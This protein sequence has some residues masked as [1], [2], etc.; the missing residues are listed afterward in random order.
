VIAACATA[1]WSLAAFGTGRPVDATAPMEQLAARIEHADSIHPDIVHD[2][3]RIL[4]VLQH[5]CSRTVCDP[6][7]QARNRA[8]RLRL[9][10]LIAAKTRS[11]VLAVSGGG[12]NAAGSV[13][14]IERR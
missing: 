10:A 6:G 1:A 7:L 3:T 8:V 13:R 4:A 5:D 12:M 11:G 9:E 14:L 2:V